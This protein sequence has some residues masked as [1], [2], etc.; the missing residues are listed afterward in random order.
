MYPDLY[1]RICIIELYSIVF[2]FP[3]M[4]ITTDE[5][6]DKKQSQLIQTIYLLLHSKTID[7]YNRQSRRKYHVNNN[8]ITPDVP[9]R[10]FYIEHIQWNNKIITDMQISLCTSFIQDHHYYQLFVIHN[11][12]QEWLSMI[13]MHMNEFIKHIII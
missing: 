5:A 3:S 8:I 9:I 6:F 2:H 12:Q 13:E 4:A 10:L 1:L 7:M 11:E